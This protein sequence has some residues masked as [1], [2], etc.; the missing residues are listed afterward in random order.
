MPTSAVARRANC[1]AQVVID[2]YACVEYLS[3]YAAKGEPSSSVLKNAAVEDGVSCTND[4]PL[5]FYANRE[6]PD[7]SRNIINMNFVEF[8][9][10]FKVT[11]NK[12]T[13]LP[14]NVIPRF[15]PTCSSSPKGTNFAIYCKYQLL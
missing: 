4:S 9:T 14:E 12:L 5:N 10:K 2:D 3:K 1:D 11:N 7:N 13:K 6:Q 8:G 15:F